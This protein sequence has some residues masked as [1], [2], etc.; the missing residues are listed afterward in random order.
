MWVAGEPVAHIC[1]SFRLSHDAANIVRKRLGLTARTARTR[2]ARR[3]PAD[4][5]TPEEISAAC[6]AL[7]QRHIEK[8]Q[9]EPPSRRYRDDNDIGGRTYPCDVFDSDQ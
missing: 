1:L 2:A 7:R 8:R 9:S 5:P 6:A 3:T 4:D